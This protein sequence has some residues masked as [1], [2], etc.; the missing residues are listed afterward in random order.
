MAQEK[1][2]RMELRK[3]HIGQTRIFHLLKPN[4]IKSA[5]VTCTQM[6]HEYGMEFQPKP[7]YEAI[8]V[9]ITRIK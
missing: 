2:T 5:I 8:A 4:K 3:I 7:D 6:K 9:S 1:V